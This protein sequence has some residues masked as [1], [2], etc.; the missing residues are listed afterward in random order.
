M[1]GLGHGDD[2]RPE[3]PVLVGQHPAGP[4]ESGLDL[5]ADHEDAVFS[6]EPLRLGVE[7]GLGCVDALALHRLEDEG[8][9]V[10][11]LDLG[12][13]RRC[14]I[15]R[16]LT[17]RHEEIWR[18]TLSDALSEWQDREPRGEFTLVVEGASEAGPWDETRV[19]AALSA[20]QAEGIG[21]SEAARRVARQAGWAKS[22]V[23][24]VW[25]IGRPDSAAPAK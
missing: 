22:D 7:R 15:C 5:V 25:P 11:P 14:A 12:G 8:R 6:A 2:V 21:R 3:P 13:E 17:K 10:S 9:H 16:E 1:H 23:Y 24:A 4:A 20:L 19:R 18:G